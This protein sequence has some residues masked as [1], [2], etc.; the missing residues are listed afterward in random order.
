MAARRAM[1]MMVMC[2]VRGLAMTVT[3]TVIV[4]VAGGR[5]SATLTTPDL[6][7]SRRRRGGSR[8]AEQWSVLSTRASAGVIDKV[9]QV[10]LL[11]CM[12]MGVCLCV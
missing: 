1:V 8:A 11:P 12:A 3:V 5:A 10:S 6:V 7:V 4:S 2:G 9:V